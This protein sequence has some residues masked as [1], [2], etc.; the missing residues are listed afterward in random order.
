MKV[1]DKI[2]DLFTEEVEEDT[3][4]EPVK[5]EVIQ[6]EIPAPEVK[7]EVVAEPEIDAK[8]VKQPE[9]K[10]NYPVFFD[11]KDFEDIER[12]EKKEEV[13][14]EKKEVGKELY[15]DSYKEIYKEQYKDPYS[16]KKEEK[17]H[18]SPT[19]II[20][21]VYGVLDK[22]YK[23]D[24]IV[25]KPKKS[26]IKDSSMTIDDVRNKAYGT[27]EDELESTLFGKT[28]I[29]FATK[30][31]KINYDD[32][33]EELSDAASALDLLRED[34]KAKEIEKEENKV[35]AKDNTINETIDYLDPTI[36]EDEKIDNFDDDDSTI[37]MD[38]DNMVEDVLGKDLPADDKLSESDLFN[39]IDN[40]Y[41]KG[42]K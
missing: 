13:K 30:D 32:I 11:E 23:K 9:E 24:D 12:K 14:E 20:S 25:D 5:K 16:Y 22:N 42:D 26:S 37:T 41:G 27:L 35:E 39:L 3:K 40:M 7:K 18:F 6:V 2:R 31:E 38:D 1:F 10:N 19:P 28:S 29:L 21:P 36:D 33:E 34:P 15:K 17:K 8:P 4:E